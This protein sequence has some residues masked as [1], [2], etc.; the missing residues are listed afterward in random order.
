[1][2]GDM[3]NDTSGIFF[4]FLEMRCVV[5]GSK[6]KA[7]SVTVAPLRYLYISLICIYV[8]MTKS[9]ATVSSSILINDHRI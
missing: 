3:F 8:T 6:K 2:I 5:M 9:Q 1:M 4:S 7:K